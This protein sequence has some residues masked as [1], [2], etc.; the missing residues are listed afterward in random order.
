MATF[1]IEIRMSKIGSEEG[2]AYM[3]LTLYDSISQY[4]M[5]MG[6]IYFVSLSIS[7]SVFSDEGEETVAKTAVVWSVIATLLLQLP[8]EF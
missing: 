8:Y 5:E 1:C 6:G 4:L 2:T 7:C 3:D